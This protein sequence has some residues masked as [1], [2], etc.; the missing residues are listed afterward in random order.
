M[1]GQAW[2]HERLLFTPDSQTAA[3]VGDSVFK[4]RKGE[5]AFPKGHSRSGSISKM[6]S[7]GSQT[8]YP[9]SAPAGRPGSSSSSR[10]LSPRGIIWCLESKGLAPCVPGSS[11]SRGQAPCLYWWW[12][13]SALLPMQVPSGPGLPEAAGDTCLPLSSACPAEHRLKSSPVTLQS[14]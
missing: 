5:G 10:V 9:H 11:V 1:L 6:R 13:V 2:R 4:N 12:L 7:P 14:C 8:P 3:L